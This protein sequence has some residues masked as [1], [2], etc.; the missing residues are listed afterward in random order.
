LLSTFK[1]YFSC[2]SEPAVL[3]FPE[4][5]GHA[6]R[7]YW[8]AIIREI[9]CVH[10]YISKFGIKGV[11][12]DEALWKAVL[13]ILRLQAIQDISSLG[14]VPNDSLLMFNLCDQLPGGDL[15]LETLV[16][17]SNSRESNH[18]H[19]S[20]PAS[21]MYSISVLDTVSNLGFVFGTSSNSSVESRIAVGEIT[22]GET[23]LLERVVKESKNNYKKVVSAQAT[24]DGVKV[25]GIDTNLAVMKVLIHYPFL[26]FS[27]TLTILLLTIVLLDM[28]HGHRHIHQISDTRL[29]QARRHQ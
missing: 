23:T 19:D 25:D 29:T 5:K 21:G 7:D 14:P 24:V 15:I 11:A 10:K 20:K 26:P 1:L 6:R 3:E 9:L 27:Q 22:V 2:R 13:G 18:G 16:N 4:L 8:L 28:M 12:R 17:M